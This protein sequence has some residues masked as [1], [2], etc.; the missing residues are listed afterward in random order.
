MTSKTMRE[1]PLFTRNSFTSVGKWGIPLVRKQALAVDHVNLLACSDTR[2]K[3][4]EENRKRAS[5]FLL[6]TT[7]SQVYMITRYVHWNATLNMHSF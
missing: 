5:T 6:T 1:S 7:V 2:S 3:D 4:N